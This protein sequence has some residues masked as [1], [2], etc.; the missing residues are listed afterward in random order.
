MMAPT[1][2]IHE[3]FGTGAARTVCFI[4][5]MLLYPPHTVTSRSQCSS[6]PCEFCKLW[7][8]R[9][10]SLI[11]VLCYSL[12]RRFVSNPSVGLSKKRKDDLR[13]FFNDRFGR[14]KLSM[15]ILSRDRSTSG[16]L[17][18]TE[19]FP[20]LFLEPLAQLLATL[21]RKVIQSFLADPGDPQLLT[22]GIIFQLLD[23]AIGSLQGSSSA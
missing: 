11:W 15:I 16:P 23:A 1:Q 5:F 12:G 18:I 8:L 10:L 2:R 21:N 17:S 20:E 14:L 9:N 13:E 19:Q 7:R 22:Y 3:K 6:W 4:Y